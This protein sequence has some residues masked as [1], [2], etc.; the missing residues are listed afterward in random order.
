[1]PL[2]SADTDLEVDISSGENRAIV[3]GKTTVPFKTFVALILQR[4]VTALFK[5]WG[6][7]P[8]IVD[9]ELLTHLASAQQDT[10]ENTTHLVLVTL[11]V[12]ML[13]GIFAFSILQFVLLV[14]GVTLGLKEHII[15]AACLVGTAAVA[16]M[17]S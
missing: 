8:V 5:D 16:A 15:I 3:E 11:G 9:S 10:R 14:G 6:D 7:K 12:G 4:K 2:A 17:L 13:A 1:M